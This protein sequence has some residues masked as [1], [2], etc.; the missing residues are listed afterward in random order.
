ACDALQQRSGKIVSPQSP[1][2]QHCVRQK[3]VANVRDLGREPGMG[4]REGSFANFGTAGPQAFEFEKRLAFRG[5]KFQA[6]HLGPALR[7]APFFTAKIVTPIAT[8][9]VQAF[10]E[11]RI[12]GRRGGKVTE[13]SPARSC[14][15]GAQASRVELAASQD[16][17]S[18]ARDT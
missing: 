6:L 10:L 13:T 2:I 16:R 11:A 14:I 1:S 9:D 4:E 18:L 5:E 3:S 17:D 15:S 8:A 12:D 7:P